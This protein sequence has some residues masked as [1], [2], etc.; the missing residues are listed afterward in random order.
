MRD[1][2]GNMRRVVALVA[3]V[4]VAGNTFAGMLDP[5]NAPGPTMHTLGEI[6]QKLESIAGTLSTNVGS[7][8]PGLVAKTGQTNSATLGDDGYLKKG[9]TWPNPRFTVQANTNVVLDNLTSLMWAR[10]A[11]LPGG[12]TTWSTAI[13]YCNNLTYGGYSDWRLPN[14][15][16][17]QSLIDF[18][19]NTPVLP[20]GHP[21]TDVQ[22]DYYWS[23]TTISSGS[24]YAW[25]IY[26]ADGYT[27]Y[28]AKATMFSV[29]PIRGGQ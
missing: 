9:V 10:N 16:E 7:A 20:S 12:Q 2:Y 21:F 19:Q 23:S 15:R 22:S 11:N 1:Q 4:F 6:Y 17:L 8:F 13:D 14:V 24:D 25:F 3:G 26:L 27:Y 28:G 5:T 29:W 18:S